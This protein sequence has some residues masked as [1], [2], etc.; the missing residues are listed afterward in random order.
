MINSAS[1]LTVNSAMSASMMGDD[2]SDPS[3]PE[4]GPFDESDLLASAVHDD[5]TAQ[6]AAAGM[7]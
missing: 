5:V 7:S 3:S 1:G 2:M 4:S 6:L